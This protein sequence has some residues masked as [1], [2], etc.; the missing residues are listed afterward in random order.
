MPATIKVNNEFKS[1]YHQVK[2]N[3]NWNIVPQMYIKQS[4]QWKP[5]YEYNW[6]VGEWSKCS[7]ECGRRHSNKN[8]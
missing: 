6:H 1:S 5:L 3:N 8:C 7:V 4:N 2:V